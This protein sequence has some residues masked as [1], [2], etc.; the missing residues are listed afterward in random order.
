VKKRRTFSACAVA[1]IVAF[2]VLH[3]HAKI[4]TVNTT[5]NVS[6]GPG[7]TNLVQAISLLQDGDAIH[8]NIPGSGPFYLVTPPISPDNGYPAITNNNVTIDGYTQPGALPNTNTILGSNT[9][10][11]QIVLDSRAGGFRVEGIP[12]LSLQEASVLLVKGATNVTIRGLDFLGPGIGSSTQADPAT[13]AI[14][15]AL[16][17]ANGHVNGCWFGVAP[18]QT[19]IF[20]FQDAVTAFQGNGFPNGIVIGV[21]KNAPDA[22]TARSQFNVIVGEY[23]PLGLEGRDQRISGNFFNVF[24]DGVTDY[25]VSGIGDHTLQAFIEIGRSGDNLVIGT[26]GDGHNDADERNIFGGVTL[27]DDFNLLEWYG[28]TSS[29][30]VVAGNY[31]G[32][33]V[34]GVT[35]FT[36]SMTVLGGLH[37]STTMRF[38][39]DFDG[40][41]D[42]VEGN[43]VSMN[44]P[45]DDLF[46]DPTSSAPYD[47][48]VVEYGA[49]ISFRG[50]RLLGAELMPFT[51][52]DGFG[53]DLPK[54]AQ[55]CSNYISAPFFPTLSTNSTS[56]LLKGTVPPGVSLFTN[57]V[58]DVYLADDEAWTNGQKFQFSELAYTDPQTSQTE[59]YGFTEGKTWLA[60]FNLN[61]SANHDPTPGEFAFD[62]S[63][64]P[65]PANALVTVTASYSA[66]APGA[67]NAVM[68]TSPF[69]LPVMLQVVPRL[70]I[71]GISTN[72]FLTWPTN[73]GLFTIQTTATLNPPDW[74]DLTPQPALQTVGTNYLAEISSGGKAAFFRLTR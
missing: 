69:A 48:S 7:E 70:S 58:I 33:G 31:F 9:A 45:F 42:D 24:P 13:Y 41:S 18:D 47:F 39:S 19:N 57:I 71:A 36:N 50:N 65:I 37:S 55:Y 23:I 38:G 29:N 74:T 20:R 30:T 6:P 59:Y 5:N 3:L 46:P 61:G 54:L 63:S 72:L 28:C 53:D 21:E 15:F 1:L 49:R 64:L 8:F 73:A 51:Y 26:D 10:Q 44:Y 68:H 4:I 56:A 16:G 27:C 43:V 11:I 17:S 67:H 52:A 14:S 66:D 62:I 40:V 12:G 60:S 32:V 34:D 25:N 35:R 22:A 2:S